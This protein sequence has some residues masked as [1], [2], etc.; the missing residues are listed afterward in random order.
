[1]EEILVLP[2]GAAGC[3]AEMH[4][5]RQQTWAV[6][7]GE[8]I[9]HIGEADQG[10]KTDAWWMRDIPGQALLL[11]VPEVSGGRGVLIAVSGLSLLGYGHRVSIAPHHQHRHCQSLWSHS[12][13]S[14]HDFINLSSQ[15]CSRH[16]HEEANPR[17]L[18]YLS[19]WE[20]LWS[21]RVRT[22]KLTLL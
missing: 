21:R 6:L 13:R 5:F 22:V 7:R 18:F 20:Q 8:R 2:T 9:W 12:Q 10:K 15:S 19:S 1:M 3:C 14:P 17:T 16:T 11:Q 4:C